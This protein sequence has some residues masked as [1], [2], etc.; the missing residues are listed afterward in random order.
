[1]GLG[2]GMVDMNVE[3]GAELIDMCLDNVIILIQPTFRR[4]LN[5]P[6]VNS[7]RIRCVRSGHF[8]RNFF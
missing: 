3:I 8:I 4:T 7:L 1:M 2:R 6:I 5:L